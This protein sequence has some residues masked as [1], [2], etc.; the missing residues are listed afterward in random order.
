N[1][2]HQ[3]LDDTDV[4]DEIDLIGQTMRDNLVQLMSENPEGFRCFELPSKYEK[5]F[6]TP[7]KPRD[8]GFSNVKSLVE[9]LP[10]VIKMY[11][12]QTTED[13]VLLDPKRE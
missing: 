8:F 10:S 3:T 12:P 1:S 7:L 4:Q 9:Q 5:R 11:D 6:K 13:F 2:E